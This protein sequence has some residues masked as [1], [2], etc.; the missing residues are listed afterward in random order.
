MNV[1]SIAEDVADQEGGILHRAT[2]RG[3]LSPTDP[4]PS[5]ST[6]H[7]TPARRPFVAMAPPVVA[8]AG[9][10]VGVLAAGAV[11]LAGMVGLLSI[12]ENTA[13]PSGAASGIP[14]TMLALYQRAAATCPGLSGPS[15]PPLGPSS[16]AMGPQRCPG[17]IRAR[18]GPGARTN[19]IRT[20]HLFG[21]RP[22]GP[23][24]W[25]RPTEP[26]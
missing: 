14:A 8:A 5:M 17:C 2:H 24:R 22:A 21:L 1:L 6:A 11:V 26:L 7:H 18:I 13:A 23:R 12:G 16:R 20:R 10:A 4:S 19:A 25:R 9:L 3:V 15:S